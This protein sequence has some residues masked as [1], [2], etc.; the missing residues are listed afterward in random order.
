MTSMAHPEKARIFIVGNN[1]AT[2]FPAAMVG[3]HDDYIDALFNRNDRSCRELYDQ[4]RGDKGP[5]PTRKN[6]DMVRKNLARESLFDVIE[7]NV[8]CYSTPR[9]SDLTL[10]K[11]QGGKAVGR[12]IFEEVLAIV[13]P[14][15]LIAHG[16]GTIK[17]LGRVFSTQLPVAAQEQA[18]DVS[19]VRIRTILRGVSYAPIVFV[20]PSL[21]PP[22]W[23]VWQKWAEPHLAEMCA[24][25][26]E[27]LNS[28][29]QDTCA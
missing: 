10:V 8:I 5:S 28:N 14:K 4:L 22:K 21:A 19:C 7:T 13:R 16:A 18:D 20:V 24:Q 25:V 9:S 17:E 27:F 29:Q 2:D 15:V 3:S 1:P 11:N 12:H 23:N 6:I 26:W